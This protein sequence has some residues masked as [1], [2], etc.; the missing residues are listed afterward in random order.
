MAGILIL[1]YRLFPGHLLLFLLLVFLDELE[2]LIFGSINSV[3]D[4]LEFGLAA[5]SGE[6]TVSSPSVRLLESEGLMLAVKAE[7]EAED[8]NGTH[9][10]KII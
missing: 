6:N 8:L 7:D 5:D 1:A 2:D 10:S 9:I 3:S 4:V